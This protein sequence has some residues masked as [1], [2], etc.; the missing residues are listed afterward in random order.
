MVLA[1]PV[2]T[3]SAI[4]LASWPAC[5]QHLL[6]CMCMRETKSMSHMAMG[7]LR[8]R[9]SHQIQWTAAS[10]LVSELR[11]VL[12]AHLLLTPSPLLHLL[13]F[14]PCSVSAFSFRSL[15]QPCWNGSVVIC[16]LVTVRVAKLQPRWPGY[17][18]PQ[19]SAGAWYPQRLRAETMEGFEIG[20]GQHTH[21]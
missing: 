15:S 16:I 12:P 2:L 3:Y 9:R 19:R 5:I 18:L 21:I 17:T 14:K 8:V 1:P 20:F 7:G 4:S 13:S 6:M 10:S 11:E